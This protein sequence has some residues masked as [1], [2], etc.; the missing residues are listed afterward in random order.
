M[1]CG[2]QGACCRPRT[3]RRVVRASISK[4]LGIFAHKYRTYED[5]P[6]A[7]RA[8]ITIKANQRGKNPKWVHAGIKAAMTRRNGR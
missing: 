7:V 4:E 8:W 6:A 5:I 2:G 3:S 1:C